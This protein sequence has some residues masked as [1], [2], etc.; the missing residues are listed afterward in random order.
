MTVSKRVSYTG[1]VQG[2]GFRYTTRHLAQHYAV[3]GYVRN[4]P[5]GSVELI[6]EGEPA[7]VDRFLAAL[8]EQM[9]GYIEN[10]TIQDEP[11]GGYRGFVIRT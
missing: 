4:R 7:E 9:A 10:R 1:R 6:V 2:V 3:A 5:D 11:S 8:D